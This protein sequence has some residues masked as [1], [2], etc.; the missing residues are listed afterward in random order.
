MILIAETW[1][2]VGNAEIFLKGGQEEKGVGSVPSVRGT[3]TDE[4]L[5]P[6]YLLPCPAERWLE[7]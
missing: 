5:F 4:L 1:R 6:P 3:T 2:A 7:N